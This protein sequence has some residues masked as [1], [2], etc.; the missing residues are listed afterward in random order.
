MQGMHQLHH[1]LL[2]NIN[3][4]NKIKHSL[5]INKFIKN[6]FKVPSENSI[7]KSLKIR[8]LKKHYSSLKDV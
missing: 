7:W 1:A 6:F 8:I 2:I 5:K 3:T 4:N